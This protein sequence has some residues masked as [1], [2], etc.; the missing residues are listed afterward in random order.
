HR[1]FDRSLARFLKIWPLTARLGQLALDSEIFAHWTIETSGSNWQ[2]FT[3]YDFLRQEHFVPANIAQPLLRQILPAIV[4]TID[5][6]LHG[7]L[8]RGLRAP[9]SFGPGLIYFQ[10]M[11]IA[12]IALSA[13]G[14]WIVTAAITRAFALPDWVALVTGVPV[15][16]AIFLSLRPLADRWFLI[17]INNHWPYLC[18]FAR[19]EATGFD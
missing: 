4:W 5:Y 13:G 16:I 15:A 2:G 18:E 17:Q 8:L 19:G 3:R 6:L 11:L 9:A 12:W 1:L 7:A 10:L 14:A